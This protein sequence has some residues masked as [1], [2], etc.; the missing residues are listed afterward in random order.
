[1]GMGGEGGTAAPKFAGELDGI[2]SFGC[3]NRIIA[4]NLASVHTV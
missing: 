1:M 3:I 4:H 2:F